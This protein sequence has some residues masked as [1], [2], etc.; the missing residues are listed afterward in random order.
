MAR[1][2]NQQKNGVQRQPT[3]KKGSEPGHSV[4][5]VK[6]STKDSEKKKVSHEE[7]MPNGSSFASKAHGSDKS[8]QSAGESLKR[9]N[10][11]NS[12]TEGFDVREGHFRIPRRTRGVK[13]TKSGIRGWFNVFRSRNLAGKFEFLDSAVVRKLRPFAAPIIKTVGDWFERHSPMLDPITSKLQKARDFAKTKFEQVGIDSFLRMGTTS[14]FS[15]LWC[16]IFSVF[17]M[18]GIFKSLVVFAIAALVLL[19][20]GFT[21]ALL[22]TAI[23]GVVLLWFYG[24]FWT[25]S[26][27]ILLGGLAFMSSHEQ[28]ALLITTIYSVYC[29]WGYVGWLGLL[30]A[31]NLSFVSSDALLYFL[32]NNTSQHRRE[33]EQTSGQSGYFNDASFENGLAAERGPGV[34]STSGAQDTETTSEDEVTRLLSCT[35]HYSALG[36]SRYENV[37]VSILKREYRKKAML[38]HPDK[39]MG[40]EKAAEAFK[41]LQNAYEVLLDSLKRKEYDD[42]LRREELLMYLR[43][44]QSGPQKN[45]K[46][47]L[48]PSGFSQFEADG[49]DPIGDS[50]QIACK[51]CGNFHA[52]ILTKK[53]KSL[54]RWCQECK[55]F[56]QAKDGDGWVEQ[57]SEP[58]LFG[59]MRKVDS[60]TAF[61]C[62]DGKIYNATEWY[63][64]QGMRCPANTHKPC[65]QVNTG[66]SSK[67]APSKG[68]GSGQKGGGR[69]PNLEEN[70]SEEEFFE[71]VQN[72]MQSGM[73]GDP[74]SSETPSPKPPKG[75]KKKKGKNKW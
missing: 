61:V 23:S 58:L 55:D 41:K 2:N 5:D 69:V 33:P 17:A 15:V 54:A 35:N 12:T 56:H 1:K 47:G 52:W 43:Q 11:N 27:V 49:E 40:N 9:D 71:W 68:T 16:S 62:A 64:C 37:D 10:Y 44:Y 14:F 25:T 51:K 63:I 53:V 74:S 34:T 31:L 60:P 28:L 32:K 65:F 30:F 20:L 67:H 4:P 7:E 19:F 21:L 59:L 48:F 50:R 66:I 13:H 3:K 46:H 22:L 57:S 75:N 36:F 73:F 6:E 29:A 8:K 45:G 18:A 24:S 72:A 70:M 39:N 26:L 38:V 42:K